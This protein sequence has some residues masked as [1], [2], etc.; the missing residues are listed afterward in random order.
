MLEIPVPART[1]YQTR[2]FPIKNGTRAM[3]VDE[4]RV[5]LQVY[6]ASARLPVLADDCV[7][8]TS[9]TSHAERLERVEMYVVLVT[10]H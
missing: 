9:R 1:F 7:Y 8:V 3:H 10:R 2:L 6:G 5:I 4:R